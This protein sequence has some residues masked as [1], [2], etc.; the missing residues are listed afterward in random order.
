MS[1]GNGISV[2]LKE[3]DSIDKALKKFKRKL[4]NSN[5]MLE[6]FQRESYKKP[7]AIKR[8]RKLKAI[9]RNK[10][11]VLEQKRIDSR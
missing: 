5:L 9:A 10:Y 8:E 11:K 7:S 4:K 3:N 6:V 1:K 2:E